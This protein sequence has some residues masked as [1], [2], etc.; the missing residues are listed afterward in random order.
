[1]K[2]SFS[3]LALMVIVSLLSIVPAVTGQNK[4]NA[5]VGVWRI[6]ETIAADSA[7]NSAPQP[8]LFIFTPTHYSIMNVNGTTARPVFDTN[9]AA[10]GITDAQRAAVWDAFTANSGTYDFQ[11][12]QLTTHALVAKNPRVMAQGSFNVFEVKTE[13]AAVWIQSKRTN[14]GPVTGAAQIKLVR[15]N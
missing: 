13:G 11:N 4:T 10:P 12:A 5:L 14:A 8:S 7:K 2:R 6:A 15:V 9:P 1:M 3:A